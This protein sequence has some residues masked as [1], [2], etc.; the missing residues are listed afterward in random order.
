MRVCVGDL[1]VRGGMMC[2]CV[3]ESV[4]TRVWVCS[5]V[6][7]CGGRLHIHIYI[8]VYIHIYIYIYIHIHK[9][10]YMYKYT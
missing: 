10:I 3:K 4:F 9:S 7:L 2:V 5:H 1:C 6:P 8:Y